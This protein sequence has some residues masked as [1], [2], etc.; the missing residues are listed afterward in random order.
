MPPHMVHSQLTQKGVEHE[1]PLP[2]IPVNVIGISL[3]QK[4]GWDIIV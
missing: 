3:Y 2:G 4:P 1:E